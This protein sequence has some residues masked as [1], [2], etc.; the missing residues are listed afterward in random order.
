MKQRNK[1]KKI[2]EKG[3]IIKENSQNVLKEL[4]MLY[5]IYREIIIIKSTQFYKC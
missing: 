4:N 2:H 3:V 1:Q 5:D